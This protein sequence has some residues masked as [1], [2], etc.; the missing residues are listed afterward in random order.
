MKNT[1]I[2]F[3]FLFFILT[4]IKSRGQADMNQ[5]FFTWDDFV[6]NYGRTMS[7]AIDV[8]ENMVK[9]GQ[10]E[11]ILLTMDFAFVSN[12]RNNLE[13]LSTFLNENYGYILQNIKE[14]NDIWELEGEANGIPFTESNLMF[15]VL[16]MY[17]KGFEF[18]SELDGYGGIVNLNTEESI[19]LDS[20]KVDYYF[21]EGLECYNKGNL[22]GAIFNWTTVLRI[23]PK[24]PNS[25]Y[26]RAIVKDE[27]YTWKLALKDYDKAIEIAPHF[28]SAIINRAVLKDDN[29][30][31]EGAI[32]DYNKALAI[33]DISIENKQM[34]YYNRGNSKFNLGDK[35]G[36]CEDWNLALEYGS[37]SA[38]ERIEKE[39]K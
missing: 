26:S 14:S 1:F 8:A 33:E 39:C 3:T 17:K 18:D 25:Y 22:S 19:K 9:S 21:D 34:A 31:S 28:V 24:E 29:G 35:N 12:D 10:Q 23:D 16:D 37:E 11:M 5:T 6:D 38:K 27:L 30:N 2:F 32:E 36:A 20:S 13:Q 15:W 4:S 7:N